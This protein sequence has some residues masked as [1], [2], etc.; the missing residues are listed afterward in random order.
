MIQKS[1][2]K[3][4]RGLV[5]VFITATSFVFGQNY[6]IAPNDTIKMNGGMEDLATLSI[7]QVNTTSKSLNLR[8]EKL[9]ETV[10][11]NW[12]ASVCDNKMCYTTLEDSGTMNPVLPDE[13]G[14]ILLHITPHVN[15]GTAVIR[16]IVWD[17]ENLALKDTLT[18]ILVVNETSEIRIDS[19]SGIQ[20]FPNPVQNFV[21]IQS[22][23]QSR[24]QFFIND[25]IGKVIYSGVSDKNSIF[26]STEN[27]PNGLYSV[28]IRE[29]NLIISSKK[30]IVS[31]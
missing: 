7:Q 26:I 2:I 4:K 24:F 27:F 20:I 3:I 21:Y 8:W 1:L 28:S 6:T 12:E 18:Y 15:Y 29:N 14:L 25:K 13:Y 16:Y 10:P 31:H 17:I 19:N 23:L 9:S 30:I 5:V 11:S 22:N